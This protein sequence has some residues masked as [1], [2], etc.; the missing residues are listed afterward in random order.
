VVPGGARD[1]R[2]ATL[3]RPHRSDI[4]HSTVSSAKSCLALGGGECNEGVPG[5]TEGAGSTSRPPAGAVAM[6][7][8]DL[9]PYG[10]GPL[11]L[12]FNLAV[13]ERDFSGSSSG[14]SAGHG[15]ATA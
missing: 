5:T 10:V 1:G 11:S 4:W 2:P 8:G 12:I 14:V 15:T 9:V 13:L 3:H 7:P 6:G